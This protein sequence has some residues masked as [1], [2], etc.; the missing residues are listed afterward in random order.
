[1]RRSKKRMRPLLRQLWNA[2]KQ[3]FDIEPWMDELAESLLTLDVEFRVGIPK[4]V[5]EWLLPGDSRYKNTNDIIDIEFTPLVDDGHDDLERI[6]GKF[7]HITTETGVTTSTE[8]FHAQFTAESELLDTIKTNLGRH[9]SDSLDKLNK[10]LRTKQVSTKGTT[11]MKSNLWNQ[12]TCPIRMHCNFATKSR[13]SRLLTS[14]PSLAY[15][16]CPKCVYVLFDSTAIPHAQ[17][18]S[19]GGGGGGAF[20]VCGVSPFAFIA[21]VIIRCDMA[22]CKSSPVIF[23]SERVSV[24][25]ASSMSGVI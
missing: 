5:V 2:V 21:L 9:K 20:M 1:M 4:Y 17:S 10:C 23:R 6:S 13:R 3:Q 16:V 14:A 19:A 22:R 7:R 24:S 25:C 18:L 8:A 12:E 15:V 11:G